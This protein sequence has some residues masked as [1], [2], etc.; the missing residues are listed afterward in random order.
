ML[1]SWIKYTDMEGE[2]FPDWADALGWLMTLTV[3]VAI[4]G[5]MI[6]AIAVANGEDFGEVVYHKTCLLWPLK[7]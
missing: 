1:F 7:K 4:I 6:Y 3:V 5:G 2:A